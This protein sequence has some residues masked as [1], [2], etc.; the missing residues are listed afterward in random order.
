MTHVIR[1]IDMLWLLTMDVN[2]E[3]H[4]D[5]FLLA[6]KTR[7]EVHVLCVLSRFG[8]LLVWTGPPDLLYAMYRELLFP[9]SLWQCTACFPS[10]SSEACSPRPFFM[11]SGFSCCRL[12][13][14][15]Q[16]LFAESNVLAFSVAYIFG[17]LNLQTL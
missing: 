3:N 7:S 1:S 2:K 4:N 16:R 11:T 12:H 9:I 10:A 14:K 8:T 17:H 15:E 13:H 5:S 6:I